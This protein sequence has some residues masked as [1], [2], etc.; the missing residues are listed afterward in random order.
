LGTSTSATPD[1][2]RHGNAGATRGVA[3]AKRERILV[4]TSS[5]PAYPGDASGH[6][7]QA[8]V[9]EL[10]AQG[11][12]VIV[13]APRPIA[14]A[15]EVKRAAR[16]EAERHT[17]HDEAPRDDG[18]RWVDAGD[19]FGWPGVMARVRERP[20]R[21]SGV[22]RF[23]LGAVR[24]LDAIGDV[25]RVI[26]HFLLPS[27]FPVLAWSRL[28]ARHVEVVAHGSD[29]RLFAR[30]PAVVR[31]HVAR[32]LTQRRARLRCTSEELGAL[33]EGALGAAFVGKIHVRP[34]PI[35]VAGTP[36]R[37][38]ARARLGIG[39]DETLAVVV[40]RLVASKR[41]DVA[42]RAAS[43][44]GGVRAIV[45]GDGPLREAL[46]R[47]FPHVTF[48]G[49]LERD[50]A[51]MHIAA[52]DVVLSASLLEGSPTVV[53]EA[54]VLQTPVVALSAGD[55]PVRCRDDRGSIIVAPR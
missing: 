20:L 50:R 46:E 13:V 27:A 26:A 39:E 5:Y 30:A 1:P 4:L 33:L 36:D 10:R 11:H 2:P 18:V 32:A 25:D 14:P 29:A 6:F 47:E 48:V 45:V 38:G 17:A 15:R 22:A 51:L 3:G 52:A 34:S 49:K 37:R 54:R 21:A 12:A 8:E 53:R 24:E 55:L 42:L 19:A 16:V 40:A 7:V 43:L 28:R 23:V 35:S 9:H 41:V 31:G 44:V